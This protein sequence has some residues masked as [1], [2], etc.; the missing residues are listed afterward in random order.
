MATMAAVR[1]NPVIAR[2][3]KRLR[4]NGKK[5]ILA[6]TAAMRKLLTIA[7]A[8]LRDALATQLS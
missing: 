2:F 5:P 7:N 4:D 8:K 6:L 1:S 3:Y